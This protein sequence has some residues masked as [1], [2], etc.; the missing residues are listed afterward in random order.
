MYKNLST[1]AE[2]GK[3]VRQ[4]LYYNHRTHQL[5]ANQLHL[6]GRTWIIFEEVLVSK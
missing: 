4:E 3:I 6:L 2:Q 1:S 5:I